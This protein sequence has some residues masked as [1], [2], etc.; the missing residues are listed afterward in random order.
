MDSSKNEVNKE[1]KA[2][3]VSSGFENDLGKHLAEMKQNKKVK[4]GQK[5]KNDLVLWIMSRQMW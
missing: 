3:N 1:R 5:R 4:K 2:E